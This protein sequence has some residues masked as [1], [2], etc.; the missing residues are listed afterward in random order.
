MDRTEVDIPRI[1]NAQ[2]NS[3]NTYFSGEMR[4]KLPNVEIFDTVLEAQVLA[5]RRRRCCSTARPHSSLAY[6]SPAPEVQHGDW[7][8]QWQWA[9]AMSS[10]NEK[11]K[12]PRCSA[13]IYRFDA[14]CMSCGV[15]FDEG[16]A[17]ASEPPSGA[18]PADATRALLPRRR[19][20]P[21]ASYLRF[22]SYVKYL[23]Q[24]ES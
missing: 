10:E 7:Y 4:D 11:L 3:R 14:R 8:P 16:Q 12:C 1:G 17:S 20:T 24:I 22:V 2:P 6:V 9:M 5:E 18:A 15:A 21:R 13:P 23:L 19:V